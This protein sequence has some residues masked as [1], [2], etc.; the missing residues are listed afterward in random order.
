MNPEPQVRRGLLARTLFETLGDIRG[1]LAPKDALASVASRVPPNKQELSYNASGFPR[2]GTYL[3]RLAALRAALGC[4]STPEHRGSLPSWSPNRLN[5]RYHAVCTS[6]RS[7][8]RPPLR[9]TYPA[10]C[11]PTGSC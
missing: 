3:R 1:P 4:V 5:Q 11:S 8:G 9:S 6:P 2:C 10:H 7:S